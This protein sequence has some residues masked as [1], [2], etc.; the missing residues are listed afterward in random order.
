M[1]IEWQ[2]FLASKEAVIE[3]E[4]IVYFGNINKELRQS[5]NGHI[6]ANLSHIGLISAGGDDALN[7]LQGQLTND[8]NQ[9]TDNNAQLSAYCSPKGRALALFL[10]YK[11]N[12]SIYLQVSEELIEPTLKRLK[13]FV[14]RSKVTLE[15]C[16]DQFIRFG[17]SGSN[18]E[19]K[20]IKLFSNIP[21][22]DYSALQLPKIT[23]IRL[24]GVHPRF[25]LIGSNVSEMKI[26]WSTLSQEFTPVGYS[27]WELTNIQA[28]I[29][30]LS[31]ATADKFVPQMINLDELNAINFK[32][33][34]YVGQEVIARVK[35]LGK[36][37]RRIHQASIESTFTP[38]AGDTVYCGDNEAII[39]LVVS[40]QPTSEKKQALLI[41][42]KEDFLENN[43]IYLESNQ[44]KTL[45]KLISKVPLQE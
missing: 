20:L 6:M 45:V 38:Q 39:G 14:M 28:G 31:A 16:T 34:C 4:K 15:D 24:P 9:V 17:L 23:I 3:N 18:S 29:P 22:E 26:I 12:Q 42:I 5:N 27:A 13:M 25:E 36:V 33:G 44:E 19:Q 41:S 32:K 8:I 10:I 11:Q 30:T 1:N 2:N 21:T 35:Y 7:F 37:K 43:H 40:A